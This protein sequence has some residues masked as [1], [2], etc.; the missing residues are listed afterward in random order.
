[1]TKGAMFEVLVY[2]EAPPVVERE[3]LAEPEE[4]EV[5]SAVLQHPCLLRLLTF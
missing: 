3:P 2:G 4:K 5:T 1:M